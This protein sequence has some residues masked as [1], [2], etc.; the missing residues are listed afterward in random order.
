MIKLFFIAALIPYS[1]FAKPQ[2]SKTF[3]PWW[4]ESLIQY[5]TFHSIGNYNSNGSLESLPS[6]NSFWETTTLDYSGRYVFSPS[7]AMTAGINHVQTQA[8]VSTTTKNNEG[9]QTLR[10]GIEYQLNTSL[11]DFVIEGVG[12][13]SVYQVEASSTKPVYGDGAHSFGGNIWIVKKL[14]N[15]QW[16]GKAGYLYRTEGLSSLIPYQAGLNWRFGSWVLGAAAEGSWS[17]G[18]DSET[19]SA[20][21]TFLNRTSVGSFNYRSYRPN[22]NVLD[23]QAKWNV[24]NQ[25]GLIGGLG[26]TFLGRNTSDGSH[27]FVGLDIHWQV[28]QQPTENTP[29]RNA[30]VKPPK[31]SDK[32]ASDPLF[33]EEDYNQ[34][35]NDQK[36]ENF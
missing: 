18:Q 30:I 21:K 24:T 28:Y 31:A 9:V 5:D 25:F 23:F 14:G 19:E 7:F 1:A 15:L 6:A 36:H 8:N 2:L 3:R 10:G 17:V 29:L 22:T 26:S 32:K 16:Y 34:E 12:N 13:L 33:K 20:R 11:I 27:F 35:L 4:T